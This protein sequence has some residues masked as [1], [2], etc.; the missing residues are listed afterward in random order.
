M[1]PRLSLCKLSGVKV[2]T[3]LGAGDP[4]ARGQRLGLSHQPRSCRPWRSS[5]ESRTVGDWSTSVGVPQSV[6][7]AEPHTILTLVRS[8]RMARSNSAKAPTIC[9]II[10]PAG[11]VVSMA[12]VRLRN[13]AEA[14]PRRSMM[15]STSR[16]NRAI[17]GRVS[18]RPTP[19]LCEVG[20]A[21][22]RVRDGPNVRQMPSRGRSVRTQRL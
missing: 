16:S 3:L 12:S 7:L 4:L 21:A 14:S 20:R 5:S 11:V 22:D 9:I 18:R 10:R 2:C 17:A 13:P 15:V 8:R 1:C 6:P 19:R